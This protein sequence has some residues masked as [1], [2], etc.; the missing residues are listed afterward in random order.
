MSAESLKAGYLSI[1]EETILTIPK[2][3]KI[4]FTSLFLFN[5]DSVAHRFYIN[6]TIGGNKVSLG[7]GLLDTN[8]SA[9]VF[10][11]PKTLRPGEK[12]LALADLSNVLSYVLIGEQL[13][14]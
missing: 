10:D 14:L 8:E 3:S 7:T 12:L 4:Q 11:I 13:P 6:C 1:N 9:E 2:N 5:R